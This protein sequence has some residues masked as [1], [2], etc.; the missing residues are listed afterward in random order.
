MEELIKTIEI[1]YYDI[2]IKYK[3]MIN[4]KELYEKLY[5]EYY[6]YKKI[7]C[8]TDLI[9]IIFILILY[10]KEKDIIE[11]K[12]D[13]IKFYIDKLYKKLDFDYKFLNELFIFDIYYIFIYYIFIL[14][15]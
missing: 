9:I 1:K 11:N 12:Q 6:Y 3:H 13:F 7:V 10:N 4:I 8:F 15:L 2:L 5:L 14:Y